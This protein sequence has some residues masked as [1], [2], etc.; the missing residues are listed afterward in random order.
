MNIDGLLYQFK[1]EEALR[2]E[3]GKDHARLKKKSRKVHSA[4]T[5]KKFKD[6]IKN[7]A[8]LLDAAKKYGIPTSTARGMVP[9]SRKPEQRKLAV[10]MVK[11]KLNGELCVTDKLIAT[12]TGYSTHSIGYIRTELLG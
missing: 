6:A 8:R 3:R 1:N 5:V 12:R 9:N 10:S 7:G 2:S 11:M 4:E